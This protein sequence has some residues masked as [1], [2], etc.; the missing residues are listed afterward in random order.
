MTKE[1]FTQV[2]GVYPENY[3]ILRRTQNSVTPPRVYEL[4]HKSTTLLPYV[5]RAEI[6]EG[7]DGQL[8]DGKLD[9]VRITRR[10]TSEWDFKLLD[11]GNIELTTIVSSRVSQHIASG[12]TEEEARFKASNV[13]EFRPLTVAEEPDEED[14]AIGIENELSVEYS[15]GVF[16]IK[17]EA[18][19]NGKSLAEDKNVWSHYRFRVAPVEV[20][21][22][23]G[24]PVKSQEVNLNAV[25]D[26]EVTMTFLGGNI[27][28]VLLP[29]SWFGLDL[30]LTRYFR[31]AD[32]EFIYMSY[33]L[34]WS[35]SEESYA[36]LESDTPSWQRPF[37]KRNITNS[38]FRG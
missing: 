30:S 2:F 8:L 17:E 6:E 24:V 20:I 33:R 5:S 36:I 14:G 28:D 23:G 11:N 19:I 35:A 13:Y 22:E 16:N 7:E 27:E 18:L 29:Q 26:S 31:L 4:D 32:G 9:C 10:S 21:I 15:G 38:H 3:K 1:Q 12:L 34:T 25:D 37:K